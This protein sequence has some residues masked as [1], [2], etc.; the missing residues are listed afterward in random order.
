[1]NKNIKLYS[2]EEVESNNALQLQKPAFNKP[3]F[4]IPEIKKITTKSAPDG[5]DITKV[6][7]EEEI[8]AIP[9]ITVSVKNLK[10]FYDGLMKSINKYNGDISEAITNGVVTPLSSTIENIGTKTSEIDAKLKDLQARLDDIPEIG[11]APP[12]LHITGEENG[13]L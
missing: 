13:L 11:E 10:N 8:N 9:A 6:M 4:A 3:D 2:S 5:I 7:K 12:L 1:M